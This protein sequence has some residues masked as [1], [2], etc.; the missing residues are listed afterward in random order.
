ME[1]PA[2]AARLGAAARKVLPAAAVAWLAI[3]LYARWETA[4]TL[5][6]G[7]VPTPDERAALALA[8]SRSGWVQTLGYEADL[9]FYASLLV[10]ALTASPAGL[11]AR[12]LGGGFLRSFGRYSY[13]MYLL[14][15]FVAE[16]ARL[17]YQPHLTS[18]PFVVEQ[19]L[20]WGVALTLIWLVARASY[21]LFEAPILRLKRYFPMSSAGMAPSLP[22]RDRLE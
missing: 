21:G 16:F 9:F 19:V 2:A 15:L 8:F 1:E 5:A 13:A 22:G 4:V 6:P 11:L 17:L 3:V 10:I 18:L 7:Q 20:W 14:H 12:T